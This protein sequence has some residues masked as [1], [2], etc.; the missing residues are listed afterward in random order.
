ME[1][2][3]QYI[4]EIDMSTPREKPR[5]GA[6]VWNDSTYRPVDDELLVNIPERLTPDFLKN[7]PQGH[8][9]I[10][11]VREIP[12]SEM[13]T[14]CLSI[15]F[16]PR[17]YCSKKDSGMLLSLRKK[18]GLFV[19]GQVHQRSFNKKYNFFEDI[20]RHLPDILRS[21]AK[22]IDRKIP[23]QVGYASGID[24]DRA[25]KFARSKSCKLYTI[26]PN[27]AFA[28]GDNCG[29]FA[30]RVA[31]VAKGASSDIGKNVLGPDEILPLM[32]K[33]GWI[34]FAKSINV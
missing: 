3:R 13:P 4:N 33:S 9:G 2:W 5:T 1:Q 14:Y 10:I 18:I 32:L 20:D 22:K 19:N 6:I 27:F 16:G 25:A 34:D 15:D 28:G 31:A 21:N 11:L 30:L 26:I 17:N 29:S 7:I 8:A 12:D 23:D 24:F